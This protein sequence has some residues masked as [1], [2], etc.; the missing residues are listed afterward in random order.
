MLRPKA[1]LA[2]AGLVCAVGVGVPMQAQ[3]SS[4]GLVQAIKAQ[5]RVVANSPAYRQLQH[6]DANTP[7]QA[8][9][10]IP[11]FAA[12][13]SK[14]RHAAS[15]VSAASTTTSTQQRAQS[16]WVTGARQ[17]ATGI[18][19]FETGFKDLIAGR[20]ATAKAEVTKGA[21]N[22]KAGDVLSAKADKLL[23]LAP[24]D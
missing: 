3:A 19:E 13:E 21:E 16:D 24:G 12:L 4:K 22:I 17:E 11:K 1:C 20:K 14:I 8:K 10:L 7:A 2:S 15:A 9:A 5:D 18:G 6:F 23:G